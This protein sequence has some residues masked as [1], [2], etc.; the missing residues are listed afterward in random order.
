[1]YR[2]CVVPADNRSYIH[3][4]TIPTHTYNG[5][6]EK[7]IDV[8]TLGPVLCEF[9][10]YRYRHIHAHTCTYLQYIHIPA[11]HTDTYT[12]LQIHTHTCI[13]PTFGFPFLVHQNTENMTSFL[14]RFRC[15]SHGWLESVP[16][17]FEFAWM[18]VEEAMLVSRQDHTH[19]RAMR[20][21]WKHHN[22]KNK[23]L[24]SA[25]AERL[26]SMDLGQALSHVLT[27]LGHPVPVYSCGKTGPGPPGTMRLGGGYGIGGMKG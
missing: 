12:Y 1:M 17:K 6:P 22:S 15:L 8:L 21:C 14:A 4:P 10:A 5:Q 2:N 23:S 24:F 18:I 20:P 27:C 16:A 13:I 3:I 25:D 9:H 26:G 11:I 7:N 19:E